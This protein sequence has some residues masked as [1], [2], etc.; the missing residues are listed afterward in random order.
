[1]APSTFLS[2]T[3]KRPAV[4]VSSRAYNSV[5]PDLDEAR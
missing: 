1:M 2:K 5:K 3:K 4:V